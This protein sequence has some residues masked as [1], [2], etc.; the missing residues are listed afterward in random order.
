M[1]VIKAKAKDEHFDE[2]QS[3]TSYGYQLP[4]RVGWFGR[5][6]NNTE[7]LNLQPDHVQYLQKIKPYKR[8]FRVVKP[9][10]SGL[11]EKTK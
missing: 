4:F 11:Y 3:E 6:G 9:H 7:V 10:T 8:R 1:D 5:P 2:K